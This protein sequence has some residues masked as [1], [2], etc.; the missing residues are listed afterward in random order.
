[1]NYITLVIGTIM[2]V[3]F[4]WYFSLKEKRYHGIA[5]FFSFESIF[6]LVMLNWRVWFKDPFSPYQIL[7]WLFLFASIY[8]GI[9]GFLTLHGKGKPEDNHIERTTVLVKSGIYKYIRHPLY[10][11]LFLLGTGV[12][13]KDLGLIQLIFGSVN[14]LAVYFT[15]RIEEKEMTSKFGTQYKEYMNETKMFIPYIF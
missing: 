4:S 2:I 15:A 13:L 12:M 1:M 7:S 9:A 6:I 3:A 5:R 8:P 10:C 11:S 14:L